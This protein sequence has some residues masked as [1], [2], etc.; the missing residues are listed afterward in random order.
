MTID[1]HSGARMHTP[2]RRHTLGSH[3]M[4]WRGIERAGEGGSM[5]GY[6]LCYTL[7]A[8]VSIRWDMIIKVFVSNT[9]WLPFCVPHET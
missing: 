1:L 5:T 8:Y 7:A 6:S 9:D 3:C 2:P 4:T